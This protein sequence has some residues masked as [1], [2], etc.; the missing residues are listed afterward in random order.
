[1]GQDRPFTEREKVFALRAIQ[2]YRD[3]WDLLE[4]ENLERDVQ[5]FIERH[6]KDKIYLEHHSAQDVQE[7]DRRVDEA[8]SSSTPA[9][10]E[11]PHTD[12]E[13]NMIGLKARFVQ[14]T[15]TF[16]APD[17]AAQHRAKVERM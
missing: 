4:K 1:M 5:S 12:E 17:L 10:G 6:E 15:R 7:I 8:I 2:S 3:R 13:R 14:L 9:D 16:H 11:E